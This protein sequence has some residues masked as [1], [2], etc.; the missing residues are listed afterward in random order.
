MPLLP[1]VGGEVREAGEVVERMIARDCG[2]GYGE[3]GP[4]S[5]LEIG[6]LTWATYK[7][8]HCYLHRN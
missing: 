7:D 8:W 6:A 4:G 5:V 2:L 3:P 1:P